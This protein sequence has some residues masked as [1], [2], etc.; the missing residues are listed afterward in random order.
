V[1]LV[2]DAVGAEG[3]PDGVRLPDG[4]LA[5]SNLTMDEAVR[6]LVAFTGC[7]LADAV[8]SASTTP[9]ALLGDDS[10]GVVEA[11]RRGDLVILDAAAAV[12]ATVVGGEVVWKS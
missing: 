8:V 9:A 7:S 2:T 3:G 1:A 6:N 4:T 5:G 12:V 11:G 10:R